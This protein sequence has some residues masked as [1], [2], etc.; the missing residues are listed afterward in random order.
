M[1]GAL[2]NHGM[3]LLWKERD[4]FSSKVVALGQDI[5]RGKEPFVALDST[6]HE[7]SS[8][9]ELIVQIASNLN[10]EELWRAA[11]SYKDV[12]RKRQYG[13]VLGRIS[14]DPAY[15]AFSTTLD[16]SSWTLESVML[17]FLARTSDHFR[18]S[19]PWNRGDNYL[20]RR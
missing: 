11:R 16:E 10:I 4:E 17:N 18:A 8:Q 3:E 1:K 6:T 12:R 20:P 13:T 9:L 15:G 14:K 7:G 2:D 19:P 5:H